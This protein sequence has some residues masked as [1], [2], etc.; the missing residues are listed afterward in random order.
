MHTHVHPLTLLEMNNVDDNVKDD[1]NENV[2]KAKDESDGDIKQYAPTL[3]S[4]QRRLNFRR[5]R[6]KRLWN[7]KRF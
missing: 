5:D 6:H 4:V 1:E 3:V 2:D 7:V